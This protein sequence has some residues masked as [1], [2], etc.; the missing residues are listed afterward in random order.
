MG[1]EPRTHAEGH[2]GA[3]SDGSG[4]GGA[5]DSGVA[6][7]PLADENGGGHVKGCSDQNGECDNKCCNHFLRSVSFPILMGSL[8]ELIKFIKNLKIYIYV[9]SILFHLFIKF[10]R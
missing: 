8:Y 10:Q 9:L 3:T 7:P 1:G 4:E 5:P 6:P 2:C